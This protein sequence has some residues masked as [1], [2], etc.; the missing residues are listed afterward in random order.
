MLIK[1]LLVA[2][3]LLPFFYFFVMKLSPVFFWSLLLISAVIAQWEF[4][5]MYRIG[6]FPKW[7]GI[8]SGIFLFAAGYFSKTLSPQVLALAVMGILLVRLLNRRDPASALKDI[9]FPLTTFFYIP[10]LLFYLV[11]LRYFGPHWIVFLFGCVWVSDSLAYFIG[12]TFG[13]RRLYREISPNKTVA[14]AFGSLIGG[15]F[16]GWLLNLLLIHTMALWEAL[17]I[18]FVIGTATMAGDLVE[19]MFK[20]D[21]GVKDSSGLIPGHGGLL[22]KIDGVLFAGPVLYWV[23][24]V[25]K[26]FR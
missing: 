4:C 8:V 22:D 12:K 2:A 25:L 3:I 17:C 7:S 20:R 10:V 5:A 18:G 19:S 24:T 13:K 11:S 16:S 21:A 14:G 6:G 1:R 23:A 9:S 26:V 15:A